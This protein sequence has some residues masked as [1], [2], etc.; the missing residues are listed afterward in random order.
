MQISSKVNYSAVRLVYLA[1]AALGSWM[2]L[3]A[4]NAQAAPVTIGQLAAPD[5]PT[6]CNG[7]SNDFIQA[8]I[9]S[10]NSYVVPPPGGVITSWSTNAGPGLGQTLKMKV[11]SPTSG[12]SGLIFQVVGHD[13]PDDLVPS[14]LNTFPASIPVQTGDLIGLNDQND[15]VANNACLF[16]TGSAE[17]VFAT[18]MDGYDRADG[19]FEPIT[20]AASG[21]RLNLTATLQPPAGITAISPESG[22]IKGGASVV[23]TGHDFTG[24]S[25]VD[26]GMVP[27]S[28]FAVESDTQI[29][30][31]AP[32]TPHPGV[33]NVSLTTVAGTTPEVTPDQ[34]TYVVLAEGE[35]GPSQ[36]RRCTVPKLA[37]KKLK[38]A[39]RALTK[40][41][42]K[43]GKVKG[44]K[45]K[46]AKVKKQSPKPGNV[47]A[48]GAKVNV[49][50][51]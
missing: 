8:Q 37:G 41:E 44:H 46:S 6:V 33:V 50:L 43:L 20:P 16:E 35:V 13:G 19:A 4:A 29:T 3:A 7:G 22:S 47:L 48:P 12:P 10:G 24:A 25:S 51:G 17:D 36:R 42:C 2:I 34:F 32:P 30:A 11:F 21:Y 14:A 27:A 9:A 49:K 28:S 1:L 26:F 5:P 15:S 23:I 31:V 18:G 40:A 39:K 38:V 45:T